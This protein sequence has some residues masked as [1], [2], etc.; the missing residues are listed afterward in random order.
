[1][2]IKLRTTI[3]SNH[4]GGKIYAVCFT[5]AFYDVTNDVDKKRL[6]AYIL[7]NAISKFISTTTSTNTHSGLGDEIFV[8]TI[9]KEAP[10]MDSSMVKVDTTATTIRR[11]YLLTQ[12]GI[13][14]NSFKLVRLLTDFI[15][16]DSQ[17]VSWI[18]NVLQVSFDVRTVPPHNNI[19]TYTFATTMY[20]SEQQALS[21]LI[22][23]SYN[24][25]LLTN[26]D[27]NQ[28]VSKSNIIEFLIDSDGT[29]CTPNGVG[30]GVYVH[31]F[32]SA[33]TNMSLSSDYDFITSFIQRDTSELK[34]RVREPSYN[35]TRVDLMELRMYDSNM[36]IVDYTG[37]LFFPAG[38]QV[39]GRTDFNLLNDGLKM[40]GGFKGVTWETASAG[41]TLITVVPTNTINF[42]SVKFIRF[43]YYRVFS[44]PSWELLDANNNIIGDNNYTV[45]INSNAKTKA[46][47]VEEMSVANEFQQLDVSL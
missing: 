29:I 24:S 16:N 1:M 43:F 9:S 2:P 12:H 32:A 19:N 6:I 40:Q 39:D 13:N 15:V 21:K 26:N 4:V 10:N 36:D 34:F 23:P 47:T 37:S 45:R 33:D 30:K 38:S 20:H 14:K 3:N 11:I 44:A 27:I 8:G 31:T 25:V 17:V 18:D 22:D 41:D 5:D 28:Q 46:A 35:G 7:D 42:E